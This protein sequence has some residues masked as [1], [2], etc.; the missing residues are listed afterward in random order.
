MEPS[1]LIFMST[2]WI[3]IIGSAVIT[4]TKIVKSQ[5]GGGNN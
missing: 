5:N 4:M 3:I 1:A 2:C